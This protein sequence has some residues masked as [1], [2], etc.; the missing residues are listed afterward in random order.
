MVIWTPRPQRNYPIPPRFERLRTSNVARPRSIVPC[1]SF[2]NSNSHSLLTLFFSF[3]LPICTQFTDG[4]GKLR[5]ACAGVVTFC[6]RNVDFCSF[7]PTLAT[8]LKRKGRDNC[9]CARESLQVG[10][11]HATR[12]TA[13]TT[14]RC[15]KLAN[16]FGLL[17]LL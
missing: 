11:R 15:V 14:T 9:I 6:A 16:R 12:M 10:L 1:C 2:S 17:I 5:F 7:L 8:L 3:F 4:C 13:T